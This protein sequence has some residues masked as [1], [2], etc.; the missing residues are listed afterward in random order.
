[1]LIC[2][3][4]RFCLFLGA[5]PSGFEGGSCFFLLRVPWTLTL[6]PFPLSRTLPPSTVPLPSS[7]GARPPFPLV[8]RSALPHAARIAPL[9]RPFLRV[10]HPAEAAIRRSSVSHHALV[11]ILAAVACLHSD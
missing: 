10:F 7:S 5:P 9:L 2:G 6:L 11:S 3:F 8:C 4:R 1:P